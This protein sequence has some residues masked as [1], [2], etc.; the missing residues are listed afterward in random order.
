M[1][2]TETVIEKEIKQWEMERERGEEKVQ[3]GR[4]ERRG[5]QSRA[6]VPLELETSTP[7]RPSQVPGAELGQPLPIQVLTQC[8]PESA[9]GGA[10]SRGRCSTPLKAAGFW[11][12]LI[13][14]LGSN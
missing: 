12:L 14:T 3:E 2:G 13:S 8:L 10:S 5:C 6:V 1:K 11:L 9:P 4:G 7:G